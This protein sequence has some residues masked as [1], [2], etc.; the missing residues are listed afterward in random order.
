MSASY[1]FLLP[2]ALMHWAVLVTPGANFLLVGQLAASGQ[3]RAALSA[4]LGI[5]AVTFSWALLAVLGV[6]L[7]FALHPLLRQTVQ[8]A[9]GL[10][11][12]WIAL[13]MLRSRA[14]HGGGAAQPAALGALQALRMGFLTNALNPKT[15]LFFSGVFAS[16]LPA[17]VSRGQLGA[18]V[19]LV[20]ANALV[21]HLGLALVF[22]NPWVQAQYARQ[23]RLLTRGCGGLVALLGGR[24]VWSTL[25][26]WR[27]LL[28]SRAA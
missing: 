16:V 27:V 22:S 6:G 13:R 12:L 21:W 28:L 10:Y 8:I 14:G 18:A 23:Q 20:Y 19:G 9:G 7:L 1:A 17:E 5:T 2:L 11:L 25:L 26:E 15:A 4:T 24:L 3:R